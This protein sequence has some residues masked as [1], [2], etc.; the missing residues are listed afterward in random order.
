LVQ[1]EEERKAYQKKWRAIPENKAKAKARKQTPEYKAYKK[2]YEQR[3]EVKAR[4]QTLEFREKRR[5]MDKKYRASPD[6]K[7]KRKEY[8]QTPEYRKRANKHAKEYNARPE[9]IARQKNPER[10]AEAKMIRDKPENLASAK[11]ERD[12]RRLIILKHYSKSISNSNI[13]CC[14]CCGEN[15]HADF[16][17]IDHIRGSKQMDLEPELKKLKY[18]S[19]LKGMNLHRWIIRNNFPDGF[20]ILCSNCNF[21][22]GMKKNNNQCPHEKM[23]KEEAFA[24][25]EEQSSFEV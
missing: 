7:K 16:L 14:N 24:M 10:M 19:K 6:G 11:N 25:M 18:S 20:Q 15:S 21:A 1:T 3:P 22:K 12:T 13:P 5:A 17:A 8:S 9:V 4:K 2:E 23:R